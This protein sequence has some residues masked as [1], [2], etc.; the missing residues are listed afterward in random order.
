MHRTSPLRH[1][2]LLRHPFQALQCY[3]FSFLSSASMLI[4]DK[5]TSL[6]RALPV[7]LKTS[8]SSFSASPISPVTFSML[9]ICIIFFNIQT[10]FLPFFHVCLFGHRFQHVL[11]KENLTCLKQQELMHRHI[12][13]KR[14]L[15]SQ[16]LQAPLYVPLK[17]INTACLLSLQSTLPKMKN[18]KK[19][20]DFFCLGYK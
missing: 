10:N 12:L 17:P 9:E 15:K 16:D 4:L 18:V 5:H 2:P 1:R 6:H 3:G 20:W 14:S 19:S 7:P 11:W 13:Q 8:A